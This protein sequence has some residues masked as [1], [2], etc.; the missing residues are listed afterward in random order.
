MDQRTPRRVAFSHSLTRLHRVES[1]SKLPP[2]PYS[3]FP[4]NT[5]TGHLSSPSALP[6]DLSPRIGCI[7]HISHISHISLILSPSRSLSLPRSVS[8]V[9][10]RL[11]VSSLPSPPL[12]P[13]LRKR[14]LSACCSPLRGSSPPKINLSSM[15]GCERAA[16]WKKKKKKFWTHSI[17]TSNGSPPFQSITF[18]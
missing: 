5:P 3:T 1:L 14:L 12:H 18:S 13:L 2:L 10:F 9:R 11:S 16:L 7:S 4:N 15:I 8:I 6:T 17:P